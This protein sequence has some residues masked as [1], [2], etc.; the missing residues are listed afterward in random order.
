MSATSFISL[1]FQL[2]YGFAASLFPTNGKMGVRLQNFWHGSRKGFVV[3]L[4]NR[5]PKE[6]DDR[7]AGSIFLDWDKVG[8][9]VVCEVLVVSLA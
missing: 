9:S 5:G 4:P 6:D 2:Q 3:C 7:D 1:I 8:D